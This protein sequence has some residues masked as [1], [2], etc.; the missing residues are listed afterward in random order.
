[1]ND[2]IVLLAEYFQSHLVVD[3]CVVHSEI[4]DHVSPLVLSHAVASASASS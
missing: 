2:Y 1:M 4:C 3:A